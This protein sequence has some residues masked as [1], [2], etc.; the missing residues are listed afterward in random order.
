MEQVQVLSHRNL[1]AYMMEAGQDLTIRNGVVFDEQLEHLKE[2][3]ALG[4]LEFRNKKLIETPDG[5]QPDACGLRLT[6][7]A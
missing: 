4:V 6:N 7:K 1:T 5:L 2:Y 3:E